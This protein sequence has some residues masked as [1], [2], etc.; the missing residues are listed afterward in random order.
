A[1]ASPGLAALAGAGASYGVVH[2]DVWWKN[3]H[4]AGDLLTLFDFDYCGYGWRI[5]DLAALGANGRLHGR[6]VA[7]EMVA[8][9]LAGYGEQR[10]LGAAELAALPALEGAIM[11]WA[12]GVWVFYCDAFGA[13]WLAARLATALP[14]LESWLERAAGG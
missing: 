13:Q 2:G 6:P 12:L 8:A 7:D 5:G 11:L 1:L 10:R 3:A 9:L 4:A 14:G